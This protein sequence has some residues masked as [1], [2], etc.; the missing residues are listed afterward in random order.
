MLAGVVGFF[1]W[2]GLCELGLE[3]RIY[4]LIG[5]GSLVEVRPA[6]DPYSLIDDP[7]QRWLFL[8]LRFGLLAL[9]IPVV[10]E[11]M[12]R[13]WFA[14]WVS[15]TDFE[16]VRLLDLKSNAMWAIVVYAVLAHPSEALA[17]IV[18]F[19]LINF[20]MMRTGNLWDCVVAHMVTNLMLGL[21]VVNYSQWQ[22]W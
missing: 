6:F 20:L 2:I 11:L 8:V 19:W 22:L 17:A 9:V 18:W 16:S 12:V 13:G 14:R 3:K 21:Y 7:F 4:P 15:N 5:L 10:E 1:L